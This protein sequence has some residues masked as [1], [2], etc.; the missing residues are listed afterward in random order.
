[1]SSP[2]YPDQQWLHDRWTRTVRDRVFEGATASSAPV[3]V[4]LGGQPGAGKT[5]AAGR[6]SQLHPGQQPIVL[7]GDD[8]R[9]FHPDYKQLVRDDPLRMPEVTQSVSGPMVAAAV[10]HAQRERISVVLEGTFRDPAMVTDTAAEFHRAGFAVDAV[11]VAVP[12][13]QS[14]IS[15]VDRYVSSV[16]NDQDGRWTPVAAHDAALAGMP[17]T[18]QALGESEYVDQVTIMARDGSI[19]QDLTGPATVERGRAAGRAVIDEQRRP[20][21]SPERSAWLQLHDRLEQSF[22]DVPAL[23]RIRNEP[24]VRRSW[25][26]LDQARAY[27]IATTGSTATD[28]PG[29]VREAAPQL[30]SHLAR[31]MRRE[32]GSGC[33]R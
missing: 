32:Q 7:E 31:T 4:L 8:Y 27:V 11:V 29:P 28:R 25:E 17:A 16:E 2:F 21:T 30:G 13:V 12:P 23:H 22:R 6:A 10:D 14:L 18:V 1:M 19:L 3:V 24:E 26:Q 5:A 15:T 9:R 20:L 33:E